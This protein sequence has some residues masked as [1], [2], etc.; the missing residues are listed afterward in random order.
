M[1]LGLGQAAYI[2]VVLGGV[3]RGEHLPA[4]AARRRPQV[5]A[6]RP[7]VGAVHVPAVLRQVRHRL[8]VAVGA[9]APLRAV[10]LV[11]VNLEVL[12]ACEQLPALFT[13]Q[14]FPFFGVCAS[15]GD[16]PTRFVS[17]LFMSSKS[18]RTFE[19]L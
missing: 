16:P 9:P 15:L 2:E 8:S 12:L 10:V 5:L 17:A 18:P 1:R 14:K 4:L 11:R 13:L 19:G 3:R 7:G 6:S